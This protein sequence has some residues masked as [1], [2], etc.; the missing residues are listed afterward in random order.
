MKVKSDRIREKFSSTDIVLP[1]KTEF[2]AKQ[3]L[4]GIAACLIALEF[5]RFIANGCF[6]NIAPR[7]SIRM[8][9]LNTLKNRESVGCKE[10]Q[11]TALKSSQK[12][13]F[14]NKTFRNGS[15]RKIQM[16]MKMEHSQMN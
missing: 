4:C 6:K 1:L 8:A 13:K 14:C 12:C 5:G 2:S 15:K 11:M 3:D 16:H 10:Q 9:V 7:K